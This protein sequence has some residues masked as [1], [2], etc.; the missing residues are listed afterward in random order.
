MAKAGQPQSRS[1]KV[2]RAVGQGI[3]V[4]NLLNLVDVMSVSPYA[5][6]V[7]IFGS[8]AVSMIFAIQLKKPA[9]LAY[10]VVIAA[11]AYFIG[12][13][14]GLF[15]M[16]Y[17]IWSFYRLGRRRSGEEEDP[18]VEGSPSPGNA[19]AGVWQ[20]A[21]AYVIDMVIYILLVIPFSVAVGGL[22]ESARPLNPYHQW[23]NIALIMAFWLVLSAMEGSTGATLG[24][25]AMG[26]RVVNVGG[27]KL[28]FSA[29]LMRNFVKVPLWGVPQYLFP[30]T[31]ILILLWSLGQVAVFLVAAFTRKHQ[32]FYDILSNSVV[33]RHS[34]ETYKKPETVIIF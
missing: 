2:T 11:Y 14:Q 30:D 16:L 27:S 8:L 7:W 1:N 23:I 33:L 28:T 21:A 9:D 31:G 19:Y 12:R 18:T 17:L 24:K 3:L 15:P 13:Y 26:L 34:P 25:K 22:A 20:R 6:G 29:A 10:G 4:W 5:T 32:A